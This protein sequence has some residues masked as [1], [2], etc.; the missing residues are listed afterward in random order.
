MAEVATTVTTVEVVAITAAA[1]TMATEIHKKFFW[2]CDDCR[3]SG[4]VIIRFPIRPDHLA[5]AVE[6]EHSKAH[7]NSMCAGHYLNIW[8]APM[9]GAG[10]KPR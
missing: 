2:K 5:E 3:N 6:K 8:P 4:T 10:D 7:P 9:I 1:D